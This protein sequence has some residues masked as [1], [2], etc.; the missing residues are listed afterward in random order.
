[1]TIEA[2]GQM[3]SGWWS[4]S[5]KATLKAKQQTVSKWK[6]R[7]R[8]VCTKRL[9]NIENQKEKIHKGKRRQ[10]TFSKMKKK[11]DWERIGV[12]EAISKSKA[13]SLLLCD[14]EESINGAF[15]Q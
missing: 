2:N 7:N 1:M 13:S 9:I 5:I 4:A 12:F 11:L 3:S 14:Q 6:S 8:S 10:D 15:Q